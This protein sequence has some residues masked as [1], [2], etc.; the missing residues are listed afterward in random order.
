MS[1]HTLHPPYGVNGEDLYDCTKCGQENIDPF[2]S[3]EHEVNGQPV[4]GECVKL[5]YGCN[6][7]IEDAMNATHGSE[8][9]L[10]VYELDNKRMPFH[11]ECAK[12]YAAELAEKGLVA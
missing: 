3:T 10:P 8:T 2:D 6:E 4:C 7:F 9:M 11:A 5:C 12:D 1:L